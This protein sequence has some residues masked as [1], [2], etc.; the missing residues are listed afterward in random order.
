[1]INL[2][3]AFAVSVK[4]FIRDEPGVYYEDL[5]PLISFLPRYAN[6][7]TGV[8]SEKLPLWHEDDQARHRHITVPVTQ[9]GADSAS[10]NSSRGGSP[11]SD[12]EKALAQVA[13]DR[14]LKP[15]RNPPP[16]TIYDII[17]ILRFPRWIVHKITRTARA[18]GRGKA[19]RHNEYVESH[20]PVEI[21]LVLSN[22]TAWCM[23]KG[24]LQPAVA[25]GLTA[26]LTSLQDTLSNLERICNTPLPF[27]YQV[28]LRMTI[29]L[30]LFFLPFQIEAAF[31]WMTIPG[32]AFTAFLLLGFLEIGQE[33]ENPFNYDLNDLD[34]DYFCQQIQRELHLITA[35]TMPDP[36][37]FVFNEMNQ[38]FAP[39]DLRSAKEL[40]EGGKDYS[41]PTDQM[42]PG[43]PSLRRTLV[44][45]WMDVNVLTRQ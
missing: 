8:E 3:L 36:S 33:I 16:T 14:P 7:A 18:R 24:L 22:Y 20:I 35:Y 21:T 2:L 41:H 45:S 27:A 44:K 26:N 25:T 34:L 40:V 28:H 5:Y 6:G 30:Y 4:H 19:R 37:E 43:P 31:K 29:W 17:P 39:V 9:L 12:P 23:R 10:Q 38:P 15:A 32:T 1:M 11:V 13:C 42:E